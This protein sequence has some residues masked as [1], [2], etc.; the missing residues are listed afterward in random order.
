ML[1]IEEVGKFCNQHKISIEALGMLHFIENIRTDNVRKELIE[2]IKTIS[3]ID[4]DKLSIVIESLI[5]TGFLDDFRTEK[6]KSNGEYVVSKFKVTVKFR[7]ALFVQEEDSY[8]KAK[9]LY[10]DMVVITDKT[11]I[12]R[13]SSKGSAA[14]KDEYYRRIFHQNILKNGSKIEFFKFCFILGEMFDPNNTGFPTRDADVGWDKFLL[15]WDSISRDFEKQ[16]QSQT[17][18]N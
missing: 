5:N 11:G 9:S 14:V 10:P 13:V 2:Y 18:W 4:S 8:I 3:Q 12:K 16:V 17:T 1:H 7:S 15:E 6:E